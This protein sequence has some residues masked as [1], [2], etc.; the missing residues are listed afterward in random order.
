MDKGGYGGLGARGA[1]ESEPPPL[2]RAETSLELKHHSWTRY[3]FQW[4][5]AF[6]ESQDRVSAF[7]A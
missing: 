4:P 2:A 3:L 1:G 7:A 5:R 6:L